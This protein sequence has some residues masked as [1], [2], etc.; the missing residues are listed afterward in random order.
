MS[1]PP[2]PWPNISVALS[3]SRRPRSDADKAF[4][5]NHPPPSSPLHLGHPSPF[6]FFCFFAVRDVDRPSGACTVMLSEYNHAT[7]EISHRSVNA[8]LMP[9]CY[10]DGTALSTLEGLGTAIVRSFPFA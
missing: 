2:S 1:T 5:V 4:A 9:A 8:C 3:V 7:K 6:F 10:L